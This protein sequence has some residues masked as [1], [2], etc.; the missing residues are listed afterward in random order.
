[1]SGTI[2]ATRSP[3][4][5][6]MPDSALPNRLMRARNARCVHVP[7]SSTMAGRSGYQRANWRNFQPICMSPAVQND[8]A[9]HGLALDQ[10]VALR[11]LGERQ[12][13]VDEWLDGLG[14]HQMQGAVNVGKGGI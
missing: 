6:P 1:M 2:S 10:R 4:S 12:H 11:N 3:R 5:R 7:I 9:D 14:R 8:A 13:L